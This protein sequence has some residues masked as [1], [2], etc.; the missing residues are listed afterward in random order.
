MYEKHKKQS[1]EII[2]KSC[3]CTDI[4]HKKKKKRILYTES[5]GIIRSLF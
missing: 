1:H 3:I 4:V 5:W 2:R